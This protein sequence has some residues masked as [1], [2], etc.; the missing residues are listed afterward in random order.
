[1]KVLIALS[2]LLSAALSAP[3]G[4]GAPHA[5]HAAAP[6]HG[7]SSY[8]QPAHYAYNYGVVDDYS[9]NNFGQSESRDG[10]ATTGEYHVQLPDG[11]LQTVNYHV[12]DA[13]SGYVAD[14][15]YSG[16]PHYGAAGH[17]VA[18]GVG[19]HGIGHAVAGHG[20]HGHGVA[21][22]AVGYG[23]HGVTHGIGGHAV[24]GSGHHS[25]SHGH[26]LHG[27]GHF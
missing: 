17:A 3:Q 26:A 7:A 23:T 24:H 9:G 13:Y 25:A 5:V 15:T 19:H 22:H 20:P 4:Y 14:V 10:Y 16:T 27:L 2:A 18:H 11:R 6:H 12:G 1:M 21:A 8:E